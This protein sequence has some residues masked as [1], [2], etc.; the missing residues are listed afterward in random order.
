MRTL[1]VRN[2]AFKKY[3][4]N[5]PYILTFTVKSAEKLFNYQDVPQE[6]EQ[7][8]LKYTFMII[9]SQPGTSLPESQASAMT[10][11]PKVGKDIT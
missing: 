1:F 5:V 8:A 6:F 10:D 2:T 9:F 3:F 7:R 4:F 11:D